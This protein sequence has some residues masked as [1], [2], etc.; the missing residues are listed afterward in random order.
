MT[1]GHLNDIVG[2]HD[3]AELV[4][5]DTKATTGLIRCAMKSNAVKR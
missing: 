4:K 5:G 3:S 1:T 2:K